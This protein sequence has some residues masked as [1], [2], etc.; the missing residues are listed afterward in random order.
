MFRATEELITELENLRKQ[1]E[2]LQKHFEGLETLEAD[3]CN[4]LKT[5]DVTLRITT[6]PSSWA[7]DVV[8]EE[9]VFE[10]FQHSINDIREAT[11]LFDP[12]DS[13]KV[14]EVKEVT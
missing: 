11:R 14:F 2:N 8:N 6:R 1:I 3:E 5:F 13:I 4:N 9:E 10:H 7:D 12:G